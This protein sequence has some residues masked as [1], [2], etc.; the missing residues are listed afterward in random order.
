MKGFVVKRGIVGAVSA[1]LGGLVFWDWSPWDLV[2]IGMFGFVGG[3]VYGVLF[4]LVR[5]RVS[6][7]K[8]STDQQ[9]E[10]RRG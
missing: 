5:R 2:W 1:V 8:N 9:Q 4:L 6:K 7:R 3:A 10:D